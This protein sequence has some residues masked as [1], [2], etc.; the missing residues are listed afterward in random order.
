MI[1]RSYYGIYPKKPNKCNISG[2]KPVFCKIPI[3]TKEDET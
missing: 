3:L 2:L 1:I